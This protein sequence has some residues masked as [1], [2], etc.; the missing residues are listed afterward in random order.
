MNPA[1]S[2]LIGAAIGATAGILGVLLTNILQ[3]RNQHKTWIRDKKT[4]AY[5]NTLQ[6]LFRLANKRSRLLADGKTI[7]VGTNFCHRC[8]ATS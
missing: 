6:H 2:A 8:L 4:E 7:L 5:T 1:I 3:T